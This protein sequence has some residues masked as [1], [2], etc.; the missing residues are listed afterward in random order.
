M[1]KRYLANWNGIRVLR[2]LAGLL[3][4][5]AAIQTKEWLLM[6]GGV[7]FSLMALL[8]AGCCGSSAC[9]RP[10]RKNNKQTDVISYEEVR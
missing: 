5:L 8:H 1:M 2:L 3:I 7:V 4:L 6:T 9:N 10:P